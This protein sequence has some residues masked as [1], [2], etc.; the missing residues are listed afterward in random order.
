MTRSDGLWGALIVHS[1]SERDQL[2]RQAG[3]Q[4]DGEAVVA[5]GDHYHKPGADQLSWFM[6]LSSLGFEPTPESSLINGRGVFDC[7]RAVAPDTAC[8][9][10]ARHAV[11]NLRAGEKTR[12]R[13]INV[14][15]VVNQ[16][17]SIDDHILTVIEADGQLIKPIRLKRLPIAPGQRYSVLIEEP[18]RSGTADGGQEGLFWLRT[19][20]DYDCF[21]MP[22]PA[23]LPTTMAV[24]RYGVK[25]RHSPSTTIGNSG[26]DLRSRG[27]GLDELWPA[28]F[29]GS[30]VLPKSQ[31]WPA[32]P[33]PEAGVSGEH[34]SDLHHSF[35]R[36]LLHDPAPQ[37]TPQ[38]GDRRVILN[39]RMPKLSK[40][41]LSPMGYINSSTWRAYGQPI[42]QR[43]TLGNTSLEADPRLVLELPA[44]NRVP[45]MVEVVVQNLDD[46]PHPF[47]LHGHKFWVMETFATR[48]MQGPY[49]DKGQWQS[50]DLDSAAKRDTI[51]VPRRG[52]A[53][54]RWRADNPGVWAFH[55]CVF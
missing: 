43:Y 5:F 7:Q 47:H 12:L 55:W 40:H 46:G 10:V 2:A 16:Y 20:M 42:L 15:A 33:E 28:V 44:R 26:L 3:L 54:L 19:T 8:G 34:C 31:P 51:N 27:V 37:F 11:V 13:L 21:N 22:N 48:Y 14:G 9:P 29:R 50:Y 25:A 45:H 36:P 1:K 30:A 6:S 17:V 52:Y 4:Y 32:E 24:L 49:R 18:V 23:L 41:Q 38:A 35:I 53:V 39:A